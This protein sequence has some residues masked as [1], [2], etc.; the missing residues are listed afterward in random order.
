MALHPGSSL[1]SSSLVTAREERGREQKSAREAQRERSQKG[2]QSLSDFRNICSRSSFPSSS[3]PGFSRFLSCVCRLQHNARGL[4]FELIVPE[5]ELLQA[6][7]VPDRLGNRTCTSQERG[8]REKSPIRFHREAWGQRV[9][10]SNHAP[11]R[12][13]LWSTSVCRFVRLLIDSG[14]APAHRGKGERV[15]NLRFGSVA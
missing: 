5:L 10:E 12:A 4:T 15:R 3:L 11:V 2:G 1:R 7:Q 8:T 9:L 6:R 14:I 13:L